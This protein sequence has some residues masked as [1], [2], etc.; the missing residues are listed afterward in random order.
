M[1]VL[2]TLQRNL[3]PV[4]QPP[5]IGIYRLLAQRSDLAAYTPC[6]DASVEEQLQEEDGRVFVVLRSPHGAYLRLTPAEHSLWCAM[7]GTRTVAQLATQG[8]KQHK[9]LLPVGDL[10]GE[11]RRQRFL[12]DQPGAVYQQLGAALERGRVEGW[13]QRL[14]R[15]LRGYQWSL[16]GIDGTFD[17]LYRYGGWAVFTLPFALLFLLV[18]SAGLLSF[19][20]G[21]LL[22]EH[23]AFS[24]ELNGSLPAGLLAFGAM[25][26]LS[27]GLHEIG[28]GLAVK[29][30][31]RRVRRGGL[32]FYYGL[33]VAFVDTSDVW[34]EKPLQRIAVSAAGPASDLFVGGLA[35]LIAFWLP[36]SALAPFGWRLAL[37]CYG[38]TLF[39]L[40]PLLELDGY[41]ML[42][43][44]LRLPNLRQ[45][46]LD[47]I[48]GPLWERLRAG[49]R[50]SGDERVLAVYG[51]LATGYLVI[52]G[53]IALLFWNRQLRGLLEPL[54][55]AG[56]PAGRLLVL[57]MTLLV[58]LPVGLGLLLALWSGLQSAATWLLRR[59]YGRHTGLVGVAAL[60][61][62]GLLALLP[63][64]LGAESP[65]V[66]L[67][68]LILWLLAFGALWLLHKLYRG[69]AL[70]QSINLQLLATM[71]AMLAAATRLLAVPGATLPIGLDG[72]A[73]AALLAATLAALPSSGV[74]RATTG[75][76][77]LTTALL[78]G[79]FPVAGLGL[80]LAFQVMPGVA[81]SQALLRA[82]PV[83]LGMLTLALALPMVLGL[84]DSRIVWGRALLWLG[85]L[86]QL[87]SYLLD[88][89]PGTSLA[90]A[91]AAD[92]GAAGVW[93]AAW[94]IHLLA[95]RQLSFDGLVAPRL[96]ASDE[97]TRLLHAFQSCYAGLYLALLAVYGRR[98]AQVLDDRMDIASATANWS[99]T[100]DHEQARPATEVVRMDLSAQGARYAE[101]LRFALRLV[102]ELAG[103]TFA[104]RAIQA[105]YDGLPW[106]ERET[107]DRFMFPAAPWARDLSRQFHSQR[108]SRM[109]L[110]RGLDLFIA[111]DDGE[112]EQINAALVEQTLRAAE[113][114]LREGQTPA[115]IWIVDVG[116]VGGWRA[117][118]LV[119]ELHRGEIIGDWLL[120]GG[121]ASELTYRA[122][123]ESSLLFL[124]AEALSPAVLAR[125]G[126]RAGEGLEKLR[127]L[128]RVPLFAD[129]PRHTLR[130][131][132][133]Q[134]RREQLPARSVVVRQGRSSGVLYVIRQGEAAV[135][136]REN[137]APKLVARLGSQEFF[138]ELEYLRRQPP[139]A[140]V[141]AISELDVLVLPHTALDAL[142]TD[143]GGLARGL[144]RIGSGR[145]LA[146]RGS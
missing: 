132:A 89:V 108:D 51:L 137:A 126:S 124:P 71:L 38:A 58:V 45:R 117:G 144:E 118:E 35:A 116:E 23:Q 3:P 2:D 106:P 98:R 99:V 84:R 11:L 111:L 10:V 59:G 25:L 43:D 69:A 57:A 28:H 66:L 72:L 12:C 63:F 20:A 19:V 21:L 83:Y 123:L 32:M 48:R 131:L 141:V 113:V 143:A 97:R 92:I 37:A 54:W 6:A 5:G 115:G 8:F 78:V 135:F 101:V 76:L 36:Q 40:N 41:Y 112:L 130:V 109:R 14:L 42:V 27:F 139:M 80:L 87:A 105:A 85:A 33:P 9:Q 61:L 30:L 79:A 119:V 127:L 142:L 52:A 31:G 95:L 75:E 82:T 13:G 90:L 81:L 39:N 104:R 93:C 145:L 138:G 26:L 60:L 133:Q 77:L 96:S 50:P 110:L 91:R 4:C 56:G 107:A 74:E 17:R 94:S 102:S 46:S 146:L 86:G 114:V 49:D 55:L 100:L 15:L 120:R 1:T 29:H 34:P 44:L 18:V 103:D 128:E 88:L 73:L 7:D 16:P 62:S 140:S 122:S 64:R 53:L 47:Y 24:L 67:T 121:G 70:S 68:S 22:H 65:L 129:A 125:L 136:V 134:A